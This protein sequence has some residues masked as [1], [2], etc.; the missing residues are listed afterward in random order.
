ME[1]SDIAKRT[2]TWTDKL[3]IQKC[4]NRFLLIALM[5]LSSER[6]IVGLSYNKLVDKVSNHL[7]EQ[8]IITVPE[9]S[10]RYVIP[11]DGSLPESYAKAFLERVVAIRENWN[12]DS[13]EAH[14]DEL[15]KDYFTL[16]TSNNDMINLKA[17]E[18]FEFVKSEKM[19][20]R[21]KIDSINSKISYCKHLKRICGVVTGT[22]ETFKNLVEPF[23]TEKVSYFLLAKQVI[24]ST[25]SINITKTNKKIKNS[26]NDY[27]L[28]ISRLLVKE[29]ENSISQA[30]GYFQNAKLGKGEKND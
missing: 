16:K 18:V 15:H 6:V 3:F 26:K 25:D 22:R 17:Q 11:A 13:V 20:S 10:R 4:I 5:V 14:F 29:G 9:T 27:P 8:R 2:A 28:R 7:Q 21:F 30:M 19:S 24:V 23:A 1:N 12:H